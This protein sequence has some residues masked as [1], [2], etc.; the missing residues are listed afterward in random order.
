MTS[1]E[2]VF[3]CFDLTIAENSDDDT[4]TI[5]WFANRNKKRRGC[6]RK[7]RWDPLTAFVT[8]PLARWYLRAC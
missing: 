2:T 4:T 1:G 7:G 5:Q 3:I 6:G 8:V